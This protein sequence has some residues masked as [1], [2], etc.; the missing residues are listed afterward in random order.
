[1]DVVNKWST[2]ARVQELQ[3]F[4]GL[5][6]YYKRYVQNFAGIAKPLYRLTEKGMD[7][8]WTSECAEAF[9]KL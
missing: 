6:G 7:F 1:M 4:L 2:P 8:K 9:G 5:A 3:K